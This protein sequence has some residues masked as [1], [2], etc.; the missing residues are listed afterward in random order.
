MDFHGSA[1][2]QNRHKL[3]CLIDE[4]PSLNAWRFRGR[5]FLHGGYGIKAYLI[6]QDIRQIVQEYGVHESI[7]SNCH[8][9]VAFAPNQLETAEVLSRMIGMKT[10]QKA[11]FNFRGPGSVRSW[12]TSTRRWIRSS[13]R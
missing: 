10:I 11:S 1:Q 9:R 8:V 4:F 3:L 2:L 12:T 7:V 6:A 13:A 5:A